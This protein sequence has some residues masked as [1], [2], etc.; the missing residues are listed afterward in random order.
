MEIKQDERY[1]GDD[2][3]EW[4]V[5]LEG[6]D[7]EQVDKVVWQLHPSF[8]EPEREEADPKTNFR[9]ATAGWGTFPVRAKVFMKDGSVRTL[10]H[11]L[12][13]HYPDGA[14]TGE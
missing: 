2:W 5:W 3:W 12:E 9:L 13:L 8:P 11:E 14:A 10:A 6:P 1:T 7:V 4:S